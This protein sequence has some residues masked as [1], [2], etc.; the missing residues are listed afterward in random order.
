MKKKNYNKFIKLLPAYFS[1]TYFF[2]FHFVAYRFMCVCICVHVV[3]LTLT[4]FYK[5]YSFP[6]SRLL[7]MFSKIASITA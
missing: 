7:I 1:F 6:Q 2:F 4:Y 3:F 5:L